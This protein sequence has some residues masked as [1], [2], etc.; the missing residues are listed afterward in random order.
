MSILLLPR[1][2]KCTRNKVSYNVDEAFDYLFESHEEELGQLEDVND[3]DSSTDSKYNDY[4]NLVSIATNFFISGI[5]QDTERV[6]FVVQEERLKCKRNTGPI[7]S[8]DTSS[9]ETNFDA[10]DPTIPEECLES[11]IDM[12][13]YK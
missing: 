9:D 7:I 10:F 6:E 4:D 13:P 3:R 2:S 12:T 5:D 8:F 1:I 11:N